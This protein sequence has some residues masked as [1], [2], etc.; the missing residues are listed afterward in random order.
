DVIGG[1]A[2]HMGV[3]GEDRLAQAAVA[4]G[5]EAVVVVVVRRDGERRT[6]LRR[7]V[8]GSERLARRE[9]RGVAGTGGRRGDRGNRPCGICRK[10]EVA[11]RGMAARPVDDDVRGADENLPL[12]V[13]GRVAGTAEERLEP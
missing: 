8:P 13:A 10:R 5:A 7:I 12:A 3:G 2:V 11:E 9:L 6:A 1:A 4:D